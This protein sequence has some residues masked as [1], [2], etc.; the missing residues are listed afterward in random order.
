MTGRSSLGAKRKEEV[1]AGFQV[2][3]DRA[4]VPKTATVWE[5]ENPC[6]VSGPYCEE[7]EGRS[8][9]GENADGENAPF[10]AEKS[11]ARRESEPPR[12]RGELETER[13]R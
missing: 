2:E 5:C 6:S 4:Q 12:E 8:E 7:Y 10:E 13:Y 1:F 9:A 3:R 11:E